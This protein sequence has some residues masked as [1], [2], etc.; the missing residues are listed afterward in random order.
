MSKRAAGLLL[1]VAVFYAA[2]CGSAQ[3][4]DQSEQKP[5][6]P[7]LTLD[8]AT[9][10]EIKG[11]VVLAGSP[12][13]LNPIDMGS[14]PPCAKLNTV[15]VLPA[16][17]TGSQSQLANVV[18]SLK[19]GLGN[20]RFDTPKDT[21]TLD[22]K[23][24]MYVP[25]VVALMTNQPFE[26]QN[27]D[28]ILHNVHAVLKQ[29]RSWNHSQPLGGPPIT[30]V[31]TR[32][33]FASTIVCNIHPWMRTYLFVFDNPYFAVTTTTGT[34]EL[35]DLP[36]GTYTVQAWHERFGLIDQTVTVGPQEAKAISFEFKAG[37]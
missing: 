23:S 30:A 6:G 17:V 9:V 21:V 25:R 1:A 37:S 10:G 11:T 3:R 33:E 14:A 28:A 24:C 32:T 8:P 13:T 22:Q 27:D 18:I 36:P 5:T 26:V 15:P 19:D 29:N 20:Y 2:G 31:F 7:V 35:K 34:F 16:V 4:S 12:P